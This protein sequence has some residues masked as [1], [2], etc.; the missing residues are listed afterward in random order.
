MEVLFVV[1]PIAFILLVAGFIVRAIVLD[2]RDRKTYPPDKL[3]RATPTMDVKRKAQQR[4]SVK[5]VAPAKEQAGAPRKRV[6]RKKKRDTGGVSNLE[7]LLENQQE[8]KETHP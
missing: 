7:R 3:E 5:A 1:I 8:E 2:Y 4:S 6:I